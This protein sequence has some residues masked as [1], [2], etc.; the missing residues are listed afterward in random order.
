MLYQGVI[1]VSCYLDSFTEAP[2]TDAAQAGQLEAVGSHQQVLRHGTV[3][4]AA[5]QLL[6]AQPACQGPCVKAH[7][8][9]QCVNVSKCQDPCGLSM[10][11]GSRGWQCLLVANQN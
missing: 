4:V 5:F 6:H 2:L 8:D 1:L 9:C 7:V 11:Q 3:Q 10:C